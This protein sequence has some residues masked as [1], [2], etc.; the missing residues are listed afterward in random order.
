MI[1]VN[2]QD[3]DEI[4]EYFDNAD[5]NS[6]LKCPHCDRAFAS[7]KLMHQHIRRVHKL[8]TKKSIKYGDAADGDTTYRC[9]VCQECFSKAQRLYDHRRRAHK[10]I[11]IALA[12]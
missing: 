1:G 3:L 2:E 9:N 8:K 5:G 4:Q 10:P 7:K 12:N 6:D 11:D